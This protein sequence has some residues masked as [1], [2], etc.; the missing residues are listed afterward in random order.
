MP[1]RNDEKALG[2]YTLIGRQSTPSN[3]QW[4]SYS[5]HMKGNKQDKLLCAFFPVLSSFSSLVSLMPWLQHTGRGAKGLPWQCGG[6]SGRKRSRTCKR[7]RLVQQQ[8]VWLEFSGRRS[9]NLARH[10]ESPAAQLDDFFSFLPSSLTVLFFLSEM[11]CLRR[12][13]SLCQRLDLTPA[14][15]ESQTAL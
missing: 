15:W 7:V 5:L 4:S 14:G 6:G 10:S 2:R 3:G 8:H 11:L 13:L 9:R 1:C 12:R